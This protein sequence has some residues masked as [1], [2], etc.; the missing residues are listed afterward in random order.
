MTEFS[1]L[2]ELLVLYVF[3][4]FS[5]VGFHFP[6]VLARRSVP[7]IHHGVSSDGSEQYYRTIATCYLPQDLRENGVIE[8]TAQ[9]RASP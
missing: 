6:P 8:N 1:F 4:Q 2:G 7:A 9:A 3:H 5:S